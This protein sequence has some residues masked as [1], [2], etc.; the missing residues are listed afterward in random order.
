MLWSLLHSI[1]RLLEKGIIEKSMVTEKLEPLIQ[2]FPKQQKV[3][4]LE[5]FQSIDE[6]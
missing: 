5:L 3:F 1:E 6:I 2:T 4:A